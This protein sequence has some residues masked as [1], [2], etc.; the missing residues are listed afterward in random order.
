MA[1][2]DDFDLIEF[3]NDADLI[4][5]KLVALCA[6]GP[7]MGEGELNQHLCI[8]LLGIVED[9]CTKLSRLIQ[10]LPPKIREVT[11]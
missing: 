10:Q 4:L 1:Q 8:V 7:L 9:Y 5:E 2:P 6:L 3:I 11:P